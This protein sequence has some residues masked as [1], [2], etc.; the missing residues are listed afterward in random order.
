[1]NK[2]N[3][4]HQS[5]TNWKKVDKMTDDEIDYSEIPELSDEFFKHAKLYMKHR[6]DIVTLRVDHDVLEWFK[7]QGKGY[8]TKM[9]AILKGFMMSHLHSH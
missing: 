4:E 7:K 2:K 3:L 8:Q 9:N 6:K 1:M 5:R